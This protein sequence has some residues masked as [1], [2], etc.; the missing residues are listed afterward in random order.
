MNIYTENDYRRVLRHVV[1]ASAVGKKTNLTQIASSAKIPK[2]YLSKILRGDADL[3]QDQLFRIAEDL[4][5]PN[6]EREYLA[7]LLEYSRCSYHR[8]KA[9]LK[10]RL[11]KMRQESLT[12]E[13]NLKL[14]LLDDEA[15]KKKYYSDPVYLIVHMALLIKR[16]SQFPQDIAEDFQLSKRKVKEAIQTLLDLGVLEQDENRLKVKVDAIHLAPD[17]ELI[18]AWRLQMR[19]ISLQRVAELRNDEYSL[20]TVIAASE[21]ELLQ[22]KSRFLEMLKE[23]SPSIESATAEIVFQVNFDLHRWGQL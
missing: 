9:D 14:K 15:I 16:Y 5:L 13:D 8:R 17:S 19:L 12:S 20:T 21:N 7:T 3:N 6:K 18:K 23:L 1:K 2:S 11:E 4:N 10:H 22:F